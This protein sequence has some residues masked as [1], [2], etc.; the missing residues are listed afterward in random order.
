MRAA[1]A[2]SV[3]DGKKGAAGQIRKLTTNSMRKKK[4]IRKQSMKRNRKRIQSGR[5]YSPRKRRVPIGF[6]LRRIQYYK[7]TKPDDKTIE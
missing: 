2:R 1:L 7:S 6:I 5:K 3:Q 4:E